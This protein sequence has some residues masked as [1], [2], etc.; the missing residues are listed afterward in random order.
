MMRAKT[1]TISAL[2]AVACVT[3]L[4]AGQSVAAGTAAAAPSV[5]AAQSV[6]QQ[7]LTP[8]LAAQ[9][10]ANVNLCRSEIRFGPLTCGFSV[11]QAACAYS[12]IRPPR[13]DLR[14]IRPVSISVTVTRGVSRSAPGTC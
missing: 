12:L 7:P 3:A 10:S 14:W 6:A 9:L 1:R 13:T 2:I 8:A 4:I 5:P 11:S